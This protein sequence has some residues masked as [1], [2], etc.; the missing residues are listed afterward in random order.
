MKRDYLKDYVTVNERIIQF[1]ETYPNGRIETEIV[2]WKEGV[3]VVKAK[4]YRNLEDAN[5]SAVGHAYEIEGNGFVNQTSIL[6][7]GETSA[8]GRA[9]A[10]LGFE[11]KKSV[12][13]LDEVERAKELQEKISQEMKMEIPKDIILAYVEKFNNDNDLEEN[14]RKMQSK[15]FTYDAILQRLSK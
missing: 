14:V 13:S 7:N 1:H 11:I 10:F 15:G 4:I 12:A 6:E 9:L 8:V 3:L 5:P 2:S